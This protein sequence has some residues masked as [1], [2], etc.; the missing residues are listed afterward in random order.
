[1]PIVRQPQVLDED[2]ESQKKYYRPPFC[3]FKLDL[4]FD[5]EIPK[6]RLLDGSSGKRVEVKMSSFEDALKY[7]KFLTRHRMIIHVLRSMRV[8]LHQQVKTE[9][10]GSF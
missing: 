7:F 6:F 1:M 8:K 2:D 10:V 9:S 5:T 4:A 3:K